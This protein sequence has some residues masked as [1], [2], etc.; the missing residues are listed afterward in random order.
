MI[1]Y[2][3]ICIVTLFIISINATSQHRISGI[4]ADSVQKKMAEAIVIIKSDYRN[5]IRSI[6]TDSTGKFVF[7]DLDSGR[8]SLGVSYVGYEN[9]QINLR[10]SADTTLT[11]YMNTKQNTL[12][13]VTITGT[14]PRFERKIDRFVF[15]VSGN[16]VIK[17]LSTFELLGQT[18]MLRADEQ[19]GISILG[20]QGGVTVFINRRKLNLSGTDLINFLRELPS[21]NIE[22]IELLTIPP[23]FYDVD[24][25]VIDIITK[26]L[27]TN[28]LI[29]T[30]IGNY[31]RAHRDRGAASLSLVYNRNNFNQTTSISGSLGNSFKEIT[32][33]TTF[34]PAQDTVSTY[35]AI[36]SNRRALN[37]LNTV[38]YD[39]NQVWTLGTQAL[40]NTT[41]SRSNL[42]GDENANAFKQRI[43]GGYTTLNGNVYLR[44]NSEKKGTYAELSADLLHSSNKQ[45]N[46][47]ND[48]ADP[49]YLKTYVPQQIDGLSLKL[50]LSKKLKKAYVM[51]GGLKLART[52][53][54][55]PYEL[56]KGSQNGKL[57][58]NNLFNYREYITSG[59]VSV[60]KEFSQK[61]SAK[62]GVKI[63]N[64][65]VNTTTSGSLS[66]HYSNNFTFIVPIGYLNF[67]PNS[68]NSFSITSRLNNYRPDFTALN[69]ATIQIGPRTVSTGDPFL[70]PANGASFEFMHGISNKYYWGLNY[71]YSKNEISQVNTVLPPDTLLIQWE[72]WGNTYA[73][74]A[75]FFTS[76][77][78]T[79]KWGMSVSLNGSYYKRT[80]RETADNGKT[81]VYNT[82]AYLSINN[83]FRNIFIDGLNFLGNVSGS[84]PSRFG[85]WKQ[86]A[87]YRIDIGSSYS[88]KKL[89]LQISVMFNDITKYADRNLTLENITK[90]QATRVINNNDQRSFY[91]S[92]A[93]SF[94][95]LKTKKG[96]TRQTSNEDVRERL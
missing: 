23:P 36:L 35:S 75:W 65:R 95:N 79:N 67:S 91:I 42:T 50:D 39:L 59:Y 49:L 68:K 29:A 31:L 11:V 58:E 44:Y 85:V 12:K 81:D 32:K 74:N 78:I 34:D 7:Q 13:T 66:N 83:T 70:Q 14:E 92:V 3:A 87:T 77:N 62:L 90:E 4:V 96:S 84:T 55:T 30:L 61:W 25:P 89:G 53:V 94:G 46:E 6:A 28:G 43:T 88:I 37:I 73:Y 45:T 57:Y 2:R 51:E 41:S 52:D 27:K 20:A 8:Y 63:E 48:V 60:S 19:T 10:I 24:G 21:E 64:S 18:P 22:R 38:T 72:N 9:V 82:Q 5:T 93:R 56:T 80:I 26:K 17:G 33:T 1:T 40:F 47:F 54:K 76:Q 16:N 69:P 15:N 71:S 86:G